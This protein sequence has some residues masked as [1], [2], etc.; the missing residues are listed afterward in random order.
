MSSTKE[1]DVTVRVGVRVGARVLPAFCAL[2][3]ASSGILVAGVNTW[4][5]IGPEGAHVRMLAIDPSDPSTAYAATIAAGVFKTTDSGASWSQLDIRYD[6]GN[7]LWNVRGFAL[8]PASPQTLYVG[9][10]G[11]LFKSTDGGA[12]WTEKPGPSFANVLVVDPETPTRVYAGTYYG[13]YRSEDGGE[14]FDKLYPLSFPYLFEV[15]AI[16]IS[17][18]DRGVIY[19]GNSGGLIK[20]VD[21]GLEFVPIFVAASSLA[22]DPS[23]PN[24]VYAATGSEVAIQ[25]SVDG[26]DSWDTIDVGLDDQFVTAIIIDPSTPATLYVSTEA[27][28][29]FKTTDGGDQWNPASGGTISP[30]LSTLAIEPQNPAILWAGATG[31]GV[32]RSIDGAATWDAANSGLSGARVEVLETHS[33]RREGFSAAPSVWGSWRRRTWAR[34]G[35]KHRGIRSRTHLQRSCARADRSRPDLVRSVRW[36]LSIHRRRGRLAQ[37]GTTGVFAVRLSCD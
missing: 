24:I 17:P 9:S 26:G 18:A 14:T 4:T 30:F 36:R 28:G 31:A 32:F 3:V 37:E 12:S 5:P 25:K 8:D 16:A 15:E 22:I 29:V 6:N 33:L 19:A 27:G 20:S 10:V 2:L 1:A 34:T 11:A 35:A 23:Q 21:D 13:L 7:R